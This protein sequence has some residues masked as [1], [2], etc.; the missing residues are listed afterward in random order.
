MVRA[1]VAVR[2]ATVVAVAAATM[3]GASGSVGAR[4][5][6]EATT[7]SLDVGASRPGS[8]T[9]LRARST[10]ATGYVAPR[11]LP[12]TR[13]SNV[14]S[15]FVVTYRGF[16]SAAKASFQRAVD[17]WS[18]LVRSS[19]PIRIDATWTGLDPG[20]LG[21]AGPSDFFRDY[22]GAPRS[23]TWYPVALANARA[24]Q[25]LSSSPDVEAVFASNRSDWYFGTD[26]NVPANKID[27]TSVVLHE[28]GHGLGITDSTQVSGGLGYWGAG[29]T[30]PFAFDRFAQSSG[31]TAVSSYGRGTSALASVLQSDAMR[32]G[33]G[34]A[35]A[36]N[37][38]TKPR[39]YSPFPYEPGSSVAHLDEDVFPT[40]DDDA[41]MTPYLDDGEALHDPGDIVLGMLRDLGWT[42]AGAKGVPAAPSLTTAL[43]G[44]QRAILAW[45]PPKD[46]GRQYLTGYRVYRYPNGSSSADASFDLP[47]GTLSTS[48]TSLV[49]GTPYRFAVAALNPS[50]ASAPSA[51]SATIVPQDLAPFS[52]SDAFVRQQFLDF[53]KREPTLAESLTWLDQLHRGVRT[54]ATTV[55]GIATI[56]G[57]Y[58]PS[59]RMTRLYSAYFTRLPDFGGY[60][61]W[62][63]RLRRGSSLKKVSDTFA[64]SSEFKTKYGSLSNTAFVNLV[65]Q[66]VLGRAP[67][68]GGRDFW[69]RRLNARTVSRGQVMLNFSESSENTRKMESEV[70]SVLLRSAMLQRMPTATEHAADVAYLDGPAG[71]SD[72]AGQ[73]LALPEYD[74]RIP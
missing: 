50:G 24:N 25:D 18:V 34:Q 44:N 60:G 39:L 55:G 43:S 30:Y 8:M 20:I 36:A 38:G 74:A 16:P 59:T 23:G 69:V 17:L 37:G 7:A 2:L 65:Y 66:N 22:P 57:N 32:W 62:T 29:T 28:I 56:P 4:P 26:G 71:L 47:V 33:G 21:G 53:A 46:T 10:P 31:G 70:N 61:F 6:Q 63:G 19:V 14:S 45:S 51:K 41:L 64:A 42:T 54:P 58:D 5:V 68:A 13:V 3:W 11:L 1:K 48:V 27:F 72:L 35:S 12:S 67:D 9:Y 73:L 15:T 52:R 49:N 40:G